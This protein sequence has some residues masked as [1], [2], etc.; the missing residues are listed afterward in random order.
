MEYDFSIPVNS[1][2]VAI[3]NKMIE[4]QNMYGEHQKTLNQLS[5]MVA[6]IEYL[7]EILQHEINVKLSKSEKVSE[8]GKKITKE[9]LRSILFFEHKKSF[10][11]PVNTKKYPIS[12]E[13][14][15]K[16]VSM[17]DLKYLLLLFETK[18]SAAKSVMTELLSAIDV[19][20]MYPSKLY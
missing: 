2:V 3:K 5:N 14:E 1:D 10:S 6:Y 19:C 4:L 11:L 13:F 20:K 17:A 16:E 9:E 18:L 8:T 12:N 7:M 15:D